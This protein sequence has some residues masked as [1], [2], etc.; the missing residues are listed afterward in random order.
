M[1]GF[2]G[3]LWLFSAAIEEGLLWLA[4][5]GVI[6][7]VISVSYYWKV[8]RALYF[9]PAETEEPLTVTPALGVALGVA[10]VGVLFVGM[11]PATLMSLLETAA[12]TFFPG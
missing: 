1:A 8:M 7:S 3:K 2:V 10:V 12:Q 11:F 5:V 6:N 4:G 9:T